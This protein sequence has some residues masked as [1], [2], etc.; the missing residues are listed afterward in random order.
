M[1]EPGLDLRLLGPDDT[2]LQSDAR[3]V[4]VVDTLLECGV[5]I[6]GE[7]CLSVA[8]VDLVF[9]GLDLV[10]ANPDSMDQRKRGQR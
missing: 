8:D 5:V 2:F 4:D 10:L 7:L 6:R 9:V 1:A 3:L